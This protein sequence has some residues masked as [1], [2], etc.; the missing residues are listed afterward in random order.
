MNVVPEAG[1]V[2]VNVMAAVPAAAASA[3]TVSAM[4]AGNAGRDQHGRACEQVV[5]AVDF[6]E[7]LCAGQVDGLAE[8]VN[9]GEGLC[10]ISPS[11]PLNGGESTPLSG[12]VGKQGACGHLLR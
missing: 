3:V 6:D 9:D 7:T 5:H 4:N 10:K 12:E 8:T 11:E 2:P 1:V